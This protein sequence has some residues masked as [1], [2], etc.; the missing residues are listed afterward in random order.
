MRQ[1]AVQNAG[2]EYQD[3]ILKPIVKYTVARNAIKKLYLNVLFA[4]SPVTNI[5]KKI[6]SS[7]VQKNA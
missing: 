4:V 7:T 6:T 5:I 2:K 3:A 1:F